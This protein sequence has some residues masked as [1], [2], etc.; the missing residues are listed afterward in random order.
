MSSTAAETKSARCFAATYAGYRGRPTPRGLARHSILT[1][2]AWLH[3]VERLREATSC[4]PRVQILVLH[5]VFEDEIVPLRDLLRNLSKSYEFV[6]YSKALDIMRQQEIQRSYLAI[7][8]DDG[9]HSLINALPI[10]EE[11]GIHACIFI[12]PEAVELQSSGHDCYFS[13]SRLRTK[14]PLA[15]LSWSDLELFLSHGHELGNHTM[16]HAQLSGAGETVVREEIAQ[17]HQIIQAKLGSVQHFA[18]PFGQLRDFDS[19]AAEVVADCG[20]RSC[21]SSIRGC[22]LSVPTRP[23]QPIYLK[24]DHVIAAWPE[25]HTMYLL[26]RNAPTAAEWWPIDWPTNSSQED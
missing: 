15:F 24:R 18:W 26:G 9:L 22:H 23:T 10:M 12:C 25:R 20:Y 17:S 13:R 11:F 1:G 3:P 2:L 16:T 5:H 21:A 4:E 7:S 6:S 8:F 19:R 14:K